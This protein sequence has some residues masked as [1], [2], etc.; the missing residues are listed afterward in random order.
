MRLGDD[1]TMM[2]DQ[3]QHSTLLHIKILLPASFLEL[4]YLGN[5]GP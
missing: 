4:I 3:S 2:G 5:M 1:A